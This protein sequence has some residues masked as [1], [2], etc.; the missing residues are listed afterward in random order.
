[1]AR[2]AAS[3]WARRTSPLTVPRLLTEALMYTRSL[4]TREPDFNHSAKCLF[5]KH[6]LEPPELWWALYY[7]VPKNYMSNTLA[8]ENWRETQEDVQMLAQM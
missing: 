5:I 1:M 6:Y 3:N 4:L 2:R 7:T 8:F